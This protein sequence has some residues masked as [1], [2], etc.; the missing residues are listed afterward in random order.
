VATNIHV[1][2]PWHAV[3]IS[4][5]P[6]CCRASVQARNVRFLSSEAP[7]LPLAGCTSPKTCACKYK[8]YG[9]RRAGPRRTTDSDL[10][11][12]ALSAHVIARLTFKDRRTTGGRRGDDRR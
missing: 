12:N 3:A 8:H 7:P 2:N 10:Y 11:K 6:S 5:G 4:S 1:S 9:D